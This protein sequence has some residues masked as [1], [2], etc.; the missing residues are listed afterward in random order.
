MAKTK[1]VACERAAE[2]SFLPLLVVATVTAIGIAAA[3]SLWAGYCTRLFFEMVR[4][5]FTGCFG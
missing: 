1:T 4:G 5:G 2:I 3:V